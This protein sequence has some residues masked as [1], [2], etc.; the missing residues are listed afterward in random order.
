MLNTSDQL[1]Q[2]DELTMVQTSGYSELLKRV[3]V[4]NEL[5]S[6]LIDTTWA[7]AGQQIHMDG[8]RVGKVLKSI[9]N[10]NYGIGVTTSTAMGH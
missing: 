6:Q 4:T 7:G 5:M 3:D 2:M 8:T 10:R 9:S 1:K